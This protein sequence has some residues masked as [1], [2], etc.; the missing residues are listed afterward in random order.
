MVVIREGGFTACFRVGRDSFGWDCAASSS[1]LIADPWFTG[2]DPAQI[3]AAASALPC[4]AVF[5]SWA[6]A[7]APRA[8]LSASVAAIRMMF[9]SNP[10]K[11]DLER[12]AGVASTASDLP[13]E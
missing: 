8:T 12:T 7:L 6:Y 3:A 11:F 2:G 4:S 5:S 9:M 1:T 10:G 13:I